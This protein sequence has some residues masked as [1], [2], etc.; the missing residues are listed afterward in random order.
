MLIDSGRSERVKI[1]LQPITQLMLHGIPVDAQNGGLE[2][3]LELF[4]GGVIFG[5][6]GL[7]QTMA[8]TLK[9]SS[10]G[11]SRI[12]LHWEGRAQATLSCKCRSSLD[13]GLI[14]LDNIG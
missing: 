2:K 3:H 14:T 12:D 11:K 4:T 7:F 5:G 6:A 9:T 10:A 1:F 8:Q 13:L